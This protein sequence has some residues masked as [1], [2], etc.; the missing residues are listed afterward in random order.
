MLRVTIALQTQTKQDMRWAVELARGSAYP[1]HSNE[2]GSIPLT[3]GFWTN[4]DLYDPEMA[5]LSQP[6]ELEAL[7]TKAKAEQRDLFVTYSHRPN[8]LVYSAGL[9]D[10]TEDKAVFDHMGTRHG[11]EEAQ[12]AQS[13]FKLKRK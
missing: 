5:I 12:F 9:L 6:E 7:I 8:A 10:I 2:R 4:A 1:F 3:A 11:L 13:V